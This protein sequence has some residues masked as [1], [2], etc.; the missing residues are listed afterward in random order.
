MRACV[1]VRVCVCVRTCACMPACLR[2]CVRGASPQQLTAD[3]TYRHAR[4]HVQLSAGG[5]SMKHLS[6]T[7]EWGHGAGSARRHQTGR[8]DC[9]DPRGWQARQDRAG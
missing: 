9:K 7:L 6:G 3:V 5:M 4:P 2:P 1:S 8:V